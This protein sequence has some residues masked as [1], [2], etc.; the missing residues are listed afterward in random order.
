MRIG[1]Q[2]W[3]TNGDIRPFIALAG[4]LRAIGHDVTLAMTSIDNTN[5]SHLSQALHFKTMSVGSQ[6]FESNREQLSLKLKEVLKTGS[7]ARQRKIL[8][9]NAWAPV[10]KDMSDASTRLCEEND[11]VIGHSFFRPL[12]LAAMKSHRPFISVFLSHGGI[13]SRNTTPPGFP[14]VGKWMN[15]I[16]WKLVLS[17][18]PRFLK[19]ARTSENLKMILI[20]VSPVFCQRQPD[21]DERIHVCGF[22]NIPDQAEQWHMPDNLR[23][24]LTSGEPP[25]YMT[26]GTLVSADPSVQ[27]ITNITR[28]MVDAAKSAGTRAIIQ[29]HWKSITDIPEHPDIYRI[30]RAPYQF[31]F[32][33]CSTVVHHGGAGTTQLA[34]RSGCPSVVVEHLLKEQPFWGNELK[35]LGVTNKVLHRRS[36]KATKLGKEIRSVLGSP[37]I[38]EKAQKLGKLMQSKDGVKLAVELIEKQF[39]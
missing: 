1:I 33:H 28:L 17:R 27:S 37:S 5:Y 4:G 8:L 14:K 18:A 16:W 2:T 32:Q 24:F 25:V 19:N 26:F 6:F 21:W 35:R 39:K 13:P 10:A 20:A 36:I 34:T 3:G 9:A 22:F 11:I 7:V 29:S 30:T 38:R 15:P 23:R 12:L 31:I